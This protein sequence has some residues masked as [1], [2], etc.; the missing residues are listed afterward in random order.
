MEARRGDQR[1]RGAEPATMTGPARAETGSGERKAVEAAQRAG[2]PGARGSG[3]QLLIR[4]A[5]ASEVAVQRSR[6][7]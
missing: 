3:Q 1:S 2:L 6:R 7:A 5:V 4:A